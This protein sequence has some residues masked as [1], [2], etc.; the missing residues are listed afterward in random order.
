MSL[1]YILQLFLIFLPLLIAIILHEIAHG[2][3]AH[4]LGDD[5]AK[6]KGRLSL[7]PL[8]HIDLLGTIILPILLWIS[9]TGFIFGWARPVPINPYKLKKHPRDEILV[10][11]A[12]I[13]MN[14]VLALISSIVLMLVTK[15]PY[16]Y[17]KGALGIFFVHMIVFNVGLAVFN[18][19]P[20]PPLDGSKILF[21]WI[22]KPWVNK[23]LNS[24]KYG[25][26]IMVILL[27]IIPSI[28]ESLDLNW[29]IVGYYIITVTRYICSFL[30]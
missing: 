20:I 7:N 18:A 14:L 8:Q 22:S 15:I 17:I 24:Y 13:M 6:I 5:T 16:E 10:A 3:V 29:D 30:M 2:Y 9:N 26:I 11:S 12:G 21:G 25:L 4:L 28:G 1:Q 23:F 19:I 27:F